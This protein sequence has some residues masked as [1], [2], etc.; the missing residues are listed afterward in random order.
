MRIA[1]RA[2]FDAIKTNVSEHANVDTGVVNEET[3]FSGVGACSVE[4]EAARGTVVP[5]A[6]TTPLSLPTNN[7]EPQHNIEDVGELPSSDHVA[8]QRLL[9]KSRTCILASPPDA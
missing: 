8:R 9:R 5:Y 7:L 4:K 3:A 1:S 6:F 2:H